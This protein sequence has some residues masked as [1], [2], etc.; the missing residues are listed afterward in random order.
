MPKMKTI[1]VLLSTLG[2]AAGFSAPVAADEVSELKAQL[3]KVL[4]QNAALAEQIQD[5]QKRVN[6]LDSDIGSAPKNFKL[7][8]AGE[9]DGTLKLPGSDT[10]FV[11]YGFIHLDAY[12]DLKGRQAGDWAADIGSQPVGGPADDNRE[13]KTNLTART[14][15]FGIKTITPTEL[16]VL[17]TKLEADFNK[18]PSGGDALLNN[19]LITNSYSFR[20]R[21]AYG[22]LDG[23]WGKLLAGQYW[24]TFMF[25]DA[26][27]ETL[28]FNGH[29]S[30]AFVRQPM[31]RY[32]AKLGAAGELALA[33]ENAASTADGGANPPQVAPNIDKRPDLIANW[34][35]PFAM[36]SVSAQGLSTEYRYD[37]GAGTTAKKS[38]WG[39]GLGAVLKPTDKDS[40]LFQYTTGEGLGRYLPTTS[41]HIA[42]FD[43]AK[44]VQLYESDS[45]LVGW[46][47]AWSDTVR[48][49]LAYG[50]TKI[51]DNL[52]TDFSDGFLD[53]RKMDEGFANIIMGIAKNT[54]WGL[55]YSWGKRETYP[56]T[57]GPGATGT[58][59]TGKRSR[60]QTSLHFGF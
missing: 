57:T 56:W 32:T 8:T 38:G 16:G 42:V 6:K 4:E 20:L 26:L 46:A 43:P 39:F 37:D 11:F 41:Y 40:L 58:S 35:A 34:T 7:V 22:E 59:F 52:D 23:D 29:G 53:S 3:T 12:S 21:H 51:K 44:G 54:E 5:L 60:V 31:I 1:A 45:W 19:T 55:E 47:R 24:S 33:A 10:S 48:T 28:D 2:L 17:R 30:A 25:L 9:E 36:G 14:S 27:P 13:D 18:N 50:S 49:T 15:R